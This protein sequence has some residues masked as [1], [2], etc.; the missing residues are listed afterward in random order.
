MNF[1]GGGGVAKASQLNSTFGLGAA[2]AL[3]LPDLTLRVQ[4]GAG[5]GQEVGAALV[6][7]AGDS[8]CCFLD[9]IISLNALTK[10]SYN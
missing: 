5:W 3:H 4:R 10:A 9:A 2:T 6:G 8:Y 7:S 1:F